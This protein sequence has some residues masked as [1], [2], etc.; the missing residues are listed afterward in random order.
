MGFF[1]QQQQQPKPQQPT[2]PTTPKVTTPRCSMAE[3]YRVVRG[4]LDPTKFSLPY[5]QFVR[6]RSETGHHDYTIRAV[7][8]RL[9]NSLMAAEEARLL[10][11]I[12]DVAG[13]E[14]TVFAAI[15]Q[16]DSLDSIREQIEE[17]DNGSEL[18]SIASAIRSQA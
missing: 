9:S 18:E 7:E 11:G 13:D 6:V 8:Q 14:G 17:S 2:A 12:G 4:A 5:E 10:V 16:R 3:L 15:L 1:T